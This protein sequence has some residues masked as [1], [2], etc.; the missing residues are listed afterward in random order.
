LK[1]DASFTIEQTYTDEFGE[2]DSETIAAAGQVWSQ[3]RSW[4]LSILSDE[5][6]CYTLLMKTCARVTRRR[7]DDPAAIENLP[8]Y[9]SQAWRLSLL[10]ELEKE[11]GHRRLE[12]AMTESSPPT[13][14]SVADDLDRKIFLQQ[15]YKQ[16]D[17]QARRIFQYRSLGYTFPEMGEKLGQNP[18]VLRT[19]YNRQIKKLK[20][21]FTPED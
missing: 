7:T 21:L 20:K 6:A 17:K 13:P 1:I 15:V 14:N 8:A 16:M 11:N 3:A 2:I 12:A 9:L 5:Q 19:I 18:D 4:A 10:R